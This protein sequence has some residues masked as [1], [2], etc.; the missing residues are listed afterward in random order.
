[1]FKLIWFLYKSLCSLGW[2]A[3]SFYFFNWTSL[4]IR[5]F[6]LTP[7]RQ[8]RFARRNVLCG[9]EQTALFAGTK[10][11]NPPY[12]FSLDIVLSLQRSLKYIVSGTAEQFSKGRLS[13]LCFLFFYMAGSKVFIWKAGV[14][15]PLSPPPPFLPFGLAWGNSRTRNTCEGKTTTTNQWG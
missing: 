6:L 12:I 10:R 4:R 9:E 1:M 8:G 11:S 14:L 5:P 3:F 13:K 7:R 2:A 15:K